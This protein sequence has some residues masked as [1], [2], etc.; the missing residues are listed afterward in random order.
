MDTEAVT[1]PRGDAEVSEQE[2]KFPI[3]LPAGLTMEVVKRHYKEA[4]KAWSDWMRGKTPQLETYHKMFQAEPT[5]AKKS[6][7]D[8]VLP[9]SPGVVETLTSRLVKAIWGRDKLIDAMPLDPGITK[10][11]AKIVEDFLN[12]EIFYRSRGTKKGKSLIKAAIIEGVGMWRTKWCVTKETRMQPQYTQVAPGVEP[13][14]MGEAPQEFE[15][16]YWDWEESDPAKVAF[17]P[18]CIDSIANSPY[19]FWRTPMSLAELKVWEDSGKIQNVDAIA[20]ITPSYVNDKEDWE[21]KRANMMGRGFSNFQYADNKEYIVDEC[22]AQITWEVDQEGQGPNGE[23]LPKKVMT[24]KYHF[25]MVEEDV[26]VLFE[27]NGLMPKRIPGGSFPFTIDPRKVFGKSALHDIRGIQSLV[28][29]FGGKQVDLVDQAAN[30]TT[31]YDQRS[32][33]TGRTAFQRVGGLVRVD[34]VN[35]IKE[36]S[37]DTTA[38]EATQGFISYLTEFARNITAATEQAQ[39]LEGGAKTATEFAGLVQLIGTRFEDL[40]DNIIQFFC[41]PLA[42]DCL[43]HYQQYGVDGQMVVRESSVDGESKIVTRQMLSGRWQ[44]VPSGQN[45]QANKEARVKAAIEVMKILMELGNQAMV[46]PALTQGQIPNMK[47]YFDEVL[48]VLMDQRQPNNLWTQA[49]MPMLPGMPAAGGLP[50]MPPD[51]ALPVGAPAG[52]SPEQMG[53]DRPA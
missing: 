5:G 26:C 1:I 15:Y 2:A 11:T 16:S 40:A 30:R 13:L 36:A 29:T 47:A 48:M 38:I 23:P 8:L 43:D 21:K 17:D 39:G 34:D 51:E 9:V 53:M 24:G 42:Q 44:I 7:G 31:Y 4:R 20:A 50:P 52:P 18:W 27:E 41:V 12:Q 14:Y 25:I 37:I 28:D 3:S 45:A 49:P 33:L 46:N 32:G 35:G 19:G 22:F 10:D 6:K